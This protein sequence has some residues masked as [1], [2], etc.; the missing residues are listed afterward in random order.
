MRGEARGER[1]E[2][3]CVGVRL[4]G[5]A[6]ACV[7][8]SMATQMCS[9]LCHNII[10]VFLRYYRCRCVRGRRC[11]CGVR[12]NQSVKIRVN[13][14]TSA[15]TSVDGDANLLSIVRGCECRS[16]ERNSLVGT[17]LQCED[18]NQDNS[19][20][21]VFGAPSNSTNPN[22]A[23]GW[24]RLCTMR[25][26]FRFPSATRQHATRNSEVNEEGISTGAEQ[27]D[28]QVHAHISNTH[29]RVH[30]RYPPSYCARSS[31]SPC[32]RQ[33]SVNSHGG[34]NRKCIDRLP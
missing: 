23:I 3:V 25:F 18:Q 26:G 30:I 4:R 13:A 6:C 33:Q 12:R 7:H 29:A 2:V 5:C 10:V 22:S 9:Y 32:T 28:S 27:R 19:Y 17:H 15:V 14:N 21:S 11:G 31:V 8:T 20:L 16:S 1:R 34:D 24:F